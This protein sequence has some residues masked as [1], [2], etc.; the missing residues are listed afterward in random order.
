MQCF[1]PRGALIFFRGYYPLKIITS[2]NGSAEP[3]R[4]FSEVVG[5]CQLYLKKI[6][7]SKG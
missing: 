1:G 5:F 3:Q 2:H 7:A 4:L 6:I